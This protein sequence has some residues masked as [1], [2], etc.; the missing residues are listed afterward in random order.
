[1][2]TAAT[3]A[4]ALVRRVEELAER[5]EHASDPEASEA[6]QELLAATLDLYGAGLERIFR[7]L[8]TVPEVRDALVE[9]GIVASLLLIHD[10]YPVDLETRVREALDTVRPY[11]ESHGGNVEIVSLEDGVLR[12]RLQGSCNGCRAS[13]STLELAIERALDEAAPDLLGLEVEGLAEPVRPPKP[14]AVLGSAP[15]RDWLDLDGAADVESGAL[16]ALLLDGLRL[17][18]ANVGGTL[19]AYRDTCAGCGAPLAAGS[20]EAGVLTCGSCSRQFALTLAGRLVGDEELQLEP[21]PLL[22]EDGKVRVAAG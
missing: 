19:L 1:M 5:L 17:V 2:A 8:E 9:D 3:G 16:R 10:L 18:V 6:A 13:S 14:L 12:L 15:A 21:L 4:D 22:E 7:A 11:L 20:L